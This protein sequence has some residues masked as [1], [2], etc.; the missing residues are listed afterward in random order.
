MATLYVQQGP[1]RN[2]QKPSAS[3]PAPTAS[4]SQTEVISL[5]E[6]NI[7]TEEELKRRRRTFKGLARL[8]AMDLSAPDLLPP[9][10]RWCVRIANGDP[11]RRAP[12]KRPSGALTGEIAWW[13]L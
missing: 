11:S 7:P 2:L 3:G 9:P 5:L 1:W 10:R 4:P 13:I 6:R 8:R 12:C